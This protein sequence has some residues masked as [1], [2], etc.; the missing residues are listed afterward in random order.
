VESTRTAT[1]NRFSIDPAHEGIDIYD[2]TNELTT[3]IWKDKY[4]YGTEEHPFDSS[5]RVVEGVY[6]KDPDKDAKRDALEAMQK[7][8]WVPA[9]RIQA[10]AGTPNVVTLL[11]CYM[12]QDI[13]D[14]MSGIA[15]AL[16][17]AMLT[18]QQGGGI[19]FNFS[20]IRPAGAFLRRTDAVASGPLPF[21]DMWDSMCATIMSAG[22]RR[23]AMM[24]VIDCEH[25]DLV[26]FIQ[27]KHKKGRLTNFNISVLITDAFLAAVEAD[28][29]WFLGFNVPRADGR[30][31]FVVERE[32]RDGYEQW[33]AYSKW[34]ARDLWNLILENTYEWSE[35]GVIFIDRVNRRNNLAYC[36]T[37]TGTN[38]C[39]SAETLILTRQG[40]QPIGGLV[41]KAVEIWNGEGWSEVTPYSTGVNEVM[42]I[43]LSNGWTIA[44]T[45]S[46]KWVLSEG[47]IAETQ[48]LTVGNKLA[49][50]EMPI[51]CEGAVPD[52]DAYSQ[53]FYCGDG[54][55]NATESNLY[56]H[57]EGIRN[58]L[59][60]TIYNRNCKKQPGYRWVHGKMLPK[61]S[62]PINSH[63][64][65]CI[66]WLAGYLD[67]DGC[68][69]DKGGTCVIE[70]SAKDRAFLQTVGL[71]L[72]RLGVNYRMWERKDGGLKRGSNGMKY[73]CEPTAGLMISMTGAHQL[74]ELGLHCERLD[75][76]FFNRMPQGK[77]HVGH[78]VIAIT[79][80]NE[81]EETFCFTEPQRGMG[82]FNGILTKNC[83]EQPLPPNGCCN[84]GAVNLARMVKQPFTD[85]AEFDYELL[86]DI[87]A[88]GVR[89]LDNVIDV[90]LY[91]LEAQAKEEYAKRRIGIGITGLANALA[92]L[93]LRYGSGDAVR[94]TESIMSTL[95]DAT[96]LASSGLA[97]E[98]G[99]FPLWDADRW[100]ATSPVVQSLTSD[101]KGR[102]MEFG[103]RNSVMLTIAPTG[104]T[105]LYAGN[106]SAG[107]EPVFLHKMQRNVRQPDDTYKPYTAYDYG[108][109]LYCQV[110]RVVPDRVSG[111]PEYM[112]TH[113]DLTVREHIDMQAVCQD[114]IDASVSKTINCPQDLSF[115]DFKG[116]YQLAHEMGCKGCTTYRYS[117]TRGAILSASADDSKAAPGPRLLTRPEVLKGNTYKVRWPITDENYYITINDVGERPFEVFIHSTSSKYTDWTTALSLMISAIMRKGDDISFIPEEL[118]KVRSV[119]EVGYIDGRF[120]GSLV[121]VIGETI[122]KHLTGGVIKRVDK[123]PSGDSENPKAQIELIAQPLAPGETC[124]QCTQ[125]T[126]IQQEGCKVCTT[127]TYSNCH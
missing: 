54:T 34:Q 71:M 57:E 76:S 124:P 93:Q 126:L 106:V 19:G 96:Y 41:G 73:M 94:A 125:P 4:R 31:Q 78:R 1:G 75:L 103:V 60:G 8:L 7:G 36:E 101:V 16:K 2:T 65:Y 100:G 44:C 38:P 108:Y 3:D 12:S 119:D 116:I 18:M 43:A 22:S 91:P 51:V 117:E 27:A 35:P 33:Y 74:V 79:R 82:V 40:H 26:E 120:Y 121:A 113:E 6:A 63:I 97:E 28:E 88:L 90:T 37:I 21:M 46:H 123:G 122:G 23:G 14:S 118:K 85:M 115:E 114:H 67:A 69:V 59:K 30:H 32:D 110:K 49:Y 77:A 105:S 64:N 9:G 99:P 56:K 55:R 29:E 102:V 89:F 87:A 20:S 58:R 62:V 92:Q 98:R 72:N 80:G 104:T 68:V 25:P 83:G 95:R 109:L 5:R 10:G 52:I 42:L 66:D 107:L 111:L 17:D 39:V 86:H 50:A 127:C 11:N 15:D 24:A 45:P 112:V 70:A 61:N 48:E 53:G 47:V 81:P 13:H 84:L